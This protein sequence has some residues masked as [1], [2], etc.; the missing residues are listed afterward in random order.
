MNLTK[1]VEIAQ[2]SGVDAV[3]LETHKKLGG[4]VPGEVVPAQC[5]VYE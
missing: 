4:Q 3:I 2:K 1:M 5:E